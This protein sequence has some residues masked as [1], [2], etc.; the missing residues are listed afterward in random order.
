AV[1][2]RR[3]PLGRDPALLHQAQ[4]RVVDGAFV[5]PQSIVANLLEATRDSISVQRPERVEGL[6]HHQVERALQHLRAVLCHGHRCKVAQPAC[7]AGQ[8][9]V[10]MNQNCTDR[11]MDGATGN[12]VRRPLLNWPVRASERSVDSTM[13]SFLRLSTLS[14]SPESVK[15]PHRKR[16]TLRR[17]RSSL[18]YGGRRT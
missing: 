4:Q 3:A 8:G 7:K 13:Y 11:P 5:Q 14:T 17:R 16:K 15:T 10:V 12:P 18:S 6:E 2:L 9:P 1:A